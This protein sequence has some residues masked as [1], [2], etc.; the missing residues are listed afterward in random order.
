MGGITNRRSTLRYVTSTG[1]LCA[2]RWPNTNACDGIADEPSTGYGGSSA[3]RR[4][5]VPIGLCSIRRRLDSKSRMSGDVHVRICERV[6]VRFPRA[7]RLVVLCNG[8]KA[9]A[10]DMKEELK[11]ILDQMGLKLSE[12]KTKVTHITEGFK[13]LGYQIIRSVGTRGKMVP[14]VLIPESAMKRFQHKTRRILSPRSTSESTVAKIMAMNQ[15]TRGW[16][17]YYQNTSSPSRIF[18]KMTN[19]VFWGMTHW[20][21]TKYKL[22]T[23]GVM[24]RFYR[25]NGEAM[26]LKTNLITLVLPQEYKTKKLL[27]KTWHNPYT[28]KEAIV[29]ENFLWYKSLWTG[30]HNRHG[31]SDLREEVIHLKGTICAI[32]GPDC[33]SQG[34]PLHPSEVEV[35][36]IIPRAKFKDL[37]EADRMGNLQPSCTPCH[38]AKTKHDL[39]V[40]SRMR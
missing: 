36:H 33:L 8:T 21:G 15:L 13:F 30:H 26:T 7:T 29:R 39:K 3:A 16:C 17:H 22:S 28:A 19:E 18:R 23:P 40:L 9:Q 14:K 1:T 11:Q 27:V 10:L 4:G 12:E 5:S 24:K 38:R 20:L 2:G 32:Q 31:W 6:G 25:R 35:D 37:T 34:K